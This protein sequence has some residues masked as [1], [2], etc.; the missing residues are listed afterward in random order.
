MGR[1]C[2]LNPITISNVI[3]RKQRGAE[4]VPPPVAL[5]R[6]HRSPPDI[7]NTGPATKGV[8]DDE[9]G[10]LPATDDPVCRQAR[11]LC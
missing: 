11:A 1:A 8:A 6:I 5:T 10:I 9:Y 4:L 3:A 2:D 7:E